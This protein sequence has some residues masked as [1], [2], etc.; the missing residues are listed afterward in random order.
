MASRA[1]CSLRMLYSPGRLESADRLG[2]R[3]LA[4][5][6]GAAQCGGERPRLRPS[7]SEEQSVLGRWKLTRYALTGCAAAALLAG[8]GV[9]Q[10]PI[11]T[12][13]A[14]PQ[15]RTSE[16]SH[17][18]YDVSRPLQLQAFGKLPERLLSRTATDHAGAAFNRIAS[19]SAG[20]AV[21]PTRK[22][23]N[24]RLRNIGSHRRR[25]AESRYL[26][27]ITC[28]LTFAMSSST[29]KLAGS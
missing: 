14:M 26:R 1:R 3:G 29:P 28:F 24:A 25:V 22:L 7:R 5:S 21:A 23:A 9:S 17:S 8:C 10:A 2:P 16:G 18:D 4:A 13:T 6:P 20:M 19:V 11:G 27:A 12:P 15:S